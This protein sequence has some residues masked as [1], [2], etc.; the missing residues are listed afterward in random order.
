VLWLCVA[1]K[2]IIRTAAGL[3]KRSSDETEMFPKL[4]A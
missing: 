1:E 4:V 3:E 2:L